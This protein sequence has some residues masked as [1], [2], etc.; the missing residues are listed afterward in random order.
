MSW[1]DVVLM[2]L[3]RP[4][5]RAA[6]MRARKIDPNFSVAEQALGIY[7]AALKR[8]MLY[9]VLFLVVWVTALMLGKLLPIEAATILL[10]SSTLLLGVAA[11]PIAF[12]FFEHE[13]YQ[14]IAA[15]IVAAELGVGLVGMFIHIPL[16]DVVVLQVTGLYLIFSSYLG[17]AKGIRLWGN[18]F[19]AA[20]M[21]FIVLSAVAPAFAGALR[22]IPSALDN[23]AAR[24]TTNAVSAI[25]SAGTAGNTQSQSGAVT[26]QVVIPPSGPSA[27]FNPLT[28]VPAGWSYRIDNAPIGTMICW[29]SGASPVSYKEMA[30]YPAQPFSLSHEGGGIATI[31]WQ[32]YPFT[33]STSGQ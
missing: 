32:P 10:V 6:L 14:K 4:I 19:A 5:R 3:V 12:V 28:T 9:V 26:I 13:H 20:V 31:S 16:N 30:D 1:L 18:R 17:K 24:V 7:V 21:T 29:T 15:A 25:K 8:L 23:A 22:A 11:W 2:H 27:V 33:S